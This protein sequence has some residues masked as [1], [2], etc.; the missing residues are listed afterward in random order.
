M[1]INSTG[2]NMSLGCPTKHPMVK[3]PKKSIQNLPCLADKDININELDYVIPSLQTQPK[4]LV[5][6]GHN[7]SLCPLS[8]R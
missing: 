1:F 3:F 8:S 4:S 2:D 6:V 7:V 5:N